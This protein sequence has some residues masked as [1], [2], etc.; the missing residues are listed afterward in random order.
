[1]FVLCNKSA[2]WRLIEK[3]PEGDVQRAAQFTAILDF[4]QQ[5]EFILQTTAPLNLNPLQDEESPRTTTY[6]ITVN[7]TKLSIRE[8]KEL[9]ARCIAAMT[10]LNMRSWRTCRLPTPIHYAD[11]LAKFCREIGAPWPKKILRPLF[12]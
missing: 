7:T 3:V 12:L 11:M 5:N 10:R 2:G 9:L 4:G 6:E 8:L 1:M